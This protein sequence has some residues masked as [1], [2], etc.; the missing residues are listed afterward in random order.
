MIAGAAGC[1]YRFVECGS[2]SVSLPRCEAL[3]PGH[4]LG[5]SAEQPFGSIFLVYETRMRCRRCG[6]TRTHTHTHTHPRE[7]ARND[8]NSKTLNT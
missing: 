5:G 1:K 8:K 7:T 6:R 3:L 2:S 4:T